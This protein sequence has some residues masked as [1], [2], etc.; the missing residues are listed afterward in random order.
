MQIEEN[1]VS[2]LPDLQNNILKKIEISHNFSNDKT[3]PT[4]QS[5]VDTLLTSHSESL[6]VLSIPKYECFNNTTNLLTVLKKLY[7][8]ECTTKQVVE[9]FKLN[10]CPN[11]LEFEVY[12]LYDSVNDEPSVDEGE[13]CV[14][15]T[16]KRFKC[17]HYRGRD[18]HFTLKMFPGL[19][20][21]ELELGDNFLEFMEGLT[22]TYLPCL[23]KLDITGSYDVRRNNM[24]DFGKAA[25]NFPKLEHLEVANCFIKIS[26]GDQQFDFPSLLNLKL[27]DVVIHDVDSKILTANYKRSV[28]FKNRDY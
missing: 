21:L 13:A 10:R 8:D 16:L 6:K 4:F 22:N 1:C 11:L 20:E 5:F 18:I 9:I 2:I 25:R 3:L 28:K 7:F 23:W 15:S 17:K 19:R 12:C 27:T 24:F 14:V 26:D